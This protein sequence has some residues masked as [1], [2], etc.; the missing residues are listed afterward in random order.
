[1]EICSLLQKQKLSGLKPC[2]WVTGK[3]LSFDTV[4]SEDYPTGCIPF[5]EFQR[6]CVANTLVC[7]EKR[8]DTSNCGFCFEDVSSSSP[9]DGESTLQEEKEGVALI[10]PKP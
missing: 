9:K 3:L 5:V 6:Y 2:L 8:T 1:M 7:C 4:D 10:S